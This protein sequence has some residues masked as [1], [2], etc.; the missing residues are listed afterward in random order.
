M[1]KTMMPDLFVLNCY[2]G[3]ECL[4]VSN[5]CVIMCIFICVLYVCMRVCVCLVCVNV[6]VLGMH[7]FV[8]AQSAKIRKF[9]VLTI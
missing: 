7:A 5:I 1:R 4:F 8:R 6:C 2:L 9:V 3:Y